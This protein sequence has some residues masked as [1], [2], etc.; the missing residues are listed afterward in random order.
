[1]YYMTYFE[2]YCYIFM[3]KLFSLHLFMFFTYG[4]LFYMQWNAQKL[5]IQFSEFSQIHT[6]LYHHSTIYRTSP[7]PT[8]SF[9]GHPLPKATAVLIS[10]NVHWVQFFLSIYI[11]IYTLL[12]L[13]Y[14]FQQNRETHAIEGF[15]NLFFFIAEL[16]SIIWISHYLCVCFHL[17]DI[18][19]VPKCALGIKL[20][21]I[22]V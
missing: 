2:Y 7:S 18:W 5:S 1:M 11:Y 3:V 4:K 22:F 13:V 14:F 20:L 12:C 15:S 6:P 8:E 9:P 16:L 21:H 10:F 17:M 19:V